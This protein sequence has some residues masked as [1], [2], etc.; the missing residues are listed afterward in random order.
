MDVSI[1]LGL[2]VA[3]VILHLQSTLL[4]VCILYI[5]PDFNDNTIGRYLDKL[6]PY[7]PKPYIICMDSN[8]HHSSWGSEGSDKRGVVFSRWVEENELIVLNNGEPTYATSVGMYTHIDITIATPSSA[9]SL[10]WSPD[11]TL[12]TSDHFPIRITSN[13]ETPTVNKIS[14]WKIGAANWSQFEGDLNFKD[15]N[16]TSPTEVCQ[17]I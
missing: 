8:A 17:H 9:S 11:S 6:I 16:F 7:L 15:I 1:P 5:P 13:I 12:A 4:C 10:Y 2:E 14:N 3:A